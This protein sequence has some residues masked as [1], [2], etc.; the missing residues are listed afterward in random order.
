MSIR[1][2][3]YNRLA[4]GVGVLGLTFASLLNPALADP[5]AASADSS[6]NVALASNGG[7]ATVS[8][9]EV[10]D[11]RWTADKIIDGIINPD[12]SGAEQSRWSSNLTNTGL[13]WA[14]VNF[15]QAHMLDHVNIEFGSACPIK[16]DF[17]V[18]YDGSN[19][20]TI[21]SEEAQTCAE[22][23]KN[24]RVTLEINETLT[25]QPVQAIKLVS[26]QN[27]NRWG[28]S[29]WEVE[30]W[31]GE[32]P[33][34]EPNN[35]PTVA[36]SNPALVP[37]P[38]HM[39]VSEGNGFELRP[40]TSIITAP[41]FIKE[42]NLLA[43]TLRPATGLPLPVKTN[44]DANNNIVLRSGAVSQYPDSP[45]AYGL[46]SSETGIVI[47]ATNAHGIFNGTQTIVQILPGFVEHHKPTLSSW[48]VPA[49]VIA[50]SPRYSY[51]GFM[52]DIARSFLPLDEIKALVDQLSRYKI[53]VLHMHLV[54]D[55]GW[56]L[57]ITNDGRVQGDDIDYSLITTIGGTGAMLPH[58]RQA[59]REYGRTGYLTQQDWRELQD[60]AG[61][62]HIEIIPEID[63]PGHSNAILA[64]IPQI[65][66]P[67][68]SHTGTPEEPTAPGATGGAVGFS[69]LD[70]DSPVTTTFIKHVFKQV[71]EISDS[72]RIHIGGDEPWAFANRYGATVY[73]R[74]VGG[75]LDYLRSLG[76]TP[77]GWN[78]ASDAGDKW[79][80]GDILQ[81][82]N[83][84]EDRV[85]QIVNT[86]N[87]KVVVSAAN[88]TYVAQKYNPKSPIGLY[89]A[90]RDTN[91][92]NTRVFYDWN[93]PTRMG[94]SD[95]SSVL[96][97]E[98]ALWTETIRGL[99]QVEYMTFPRILA[100]AEVGWTDQ[101]RRNIDD[102]MDR[103]ARNAADLTA[104]GM[105]F[106]D[107]P[108][109]NWN[110]DI[111]GV[112]TTAPTQETRIELGYV[113]APGTKLA[114]DNQTLLVDKTNDVDGVSTSTIPAGAV[115]TVDWGDGSASEN[116][117]LTPTHP[118]D[119][120]GAPGLYIISGTHAYST[121]GLK[122]VTL[123]LGDKTTTA[124]VNV[125]SNGS[126]AAPLF[127]APTAN[128]DLTVAAGES[129]VPPAGRLPI[130]VTGL[131]PDKLADVSI[132]GV[133]NG[134]VR[135]DAEGRRSMHLYVPEKIEVGRHTITVEQD[136]KQAETTFLVW[137]D[138]PAGVK[139][140]IPNVSVLSVSSQ[141]NDAPA[142]NAL[143]GNPKTFWHTKWRNGAANYPHTLELDLNANCEVTGF[144]Y[145]A[146]ADNGNT[147][148]KDYRLYV[149]DSDTN[150]GDPV[151]SN[152]PLANVTTPQQVDFA[153]KS[154]SKVKFEA[155]TSQAGNEFAGAAEI[156]L[157][158]TCDGSNKPSIVA[159]LGG[160]RTEIVEPTAAGSLSAPANSGDISLT[161]RGLTGLVSVWD[162]SGTNLLA[163]KSNVDGVVTFTV[164]ANA[165]NSKP[166]ILH[167][168]GKEGRFI[169]T[170]NVTDDAHSSGTTPGDNTDTPS[171]DNSGSDTSGST[172]T[173]SVPLVPNPD[174]SAGGET[175]GNV[176]PEKVSRLSGQD[177]IGTSLAV[178]AQTQA[179]VL[180][181]AGYDAQI[182]ALTGAV[183][184]A[185]AKSSVVYT[186]KENLP[187]EVVQAIKERG[188]QQVT[189]LGGS[190]VVSDEVVKQLSDL[191]V[192]VDRIGGKDRYHTAKLV[193]QRVAS[194]TNQNLDT[195]PL[196][197]ASGRSWAD[198]L[199]AGPIAVKMHGALIITDDSN[200]PFVSAEIVSNSHAEVVIIG[201][202][203]VRAI[204]S[205][206][207]SPQGGRVVE[208]MGVDRYATSALTAKR[209]FA[210]ALVVALANGDAAPDAVVASAWIAQVGGPIL[211]SNTDAVP[212]VV[213][214]AI[215]A[216]AR[217]V[218]V[219]GTIR[220]SEKVFAQLS[221]R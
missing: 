44:G 43:E 199:V 31:T 110:Y 120:Y 181:L 188:V 205:T 147:R 100:G 160:N 81:F 132:D 67:G 167:V 206:A 171:G 200:V 29:L 204:H 129:P 73:K 128:G 47:N 65:N 30:A 33:S 183:P 12:A 112:A 89:W 192:K 174:S 163:Q 193:A 103:V 26:R 3:S 175:S 107:D 134:Q 88:K 95:D 17:Q 36:V 140:Y 115:V 1:H 187:S 13:P 146:R 16:W 158:G 99:D 180:F 79:Q 18:S 149:S 184:A 102:F 212:S 139:S 83:G 213:L 169:L 148:V 165:T 218:I 155:I 93:P 172:P 202:P 80:S 152:Q 108:T 161:V 34:D 208:I 210:D 219:G 62:R 97:I 127:V 162:T 39:T 40:G 176:L 87:V 71:A 130:T 126:V 178:F 173:P 111:A 201:G 55:Q 109:V 196:V 101:N 19:F 11:G 86:Q 72:N 54:D 217:R 125:S 51:R 214:D 194:M 104:A 35:E 69:Y 21:R 207:V 32:E 68:S 159:T 135:G 46:T 84:R 168:V 37:L 60:Y 64:S 143:D 66:T 5:S 105:R 27:K 59:S 63:I 61:K 153:A 186:Y 23:G 24:K 15:A 92:C 177:R 182:D 22:R 57:E 98:Q 220:I 121:P 122:Q 42:A 154:G 145:T 50:D 116:L 118:R 166:Q 49:V 76:K 96:G 157:L 91:G 216:N 124:T 164:P 119:L 28:I 136:G 82:W 75:M 52:I 189:I 198:S 7:T 170:V 190:A 9:I 25:P 6:R 2:N 117:T 151:I 221:S 14:Q 4:V 144:E 38:N 197:L 74:M 8:G 58:E 114:D 10:N 77:M 90:C 45:E 185:L 141:E 137:K 70:P 142:S 209:Y 156:K 179:K 78:E 211:L 131:V 56:R 191:G 133:Q 48:T 53:N 203:A 94:I 138:G 113:A 85:R 215:P 20:Q 195:M 150:W 41:E 106:Y 123:S